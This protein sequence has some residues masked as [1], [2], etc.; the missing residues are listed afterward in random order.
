[1]VDLAE[2]LGAQAE[3]SG[4]I[5]LRVAAHVVLDARMELLAL[6][7]EPGLVGAVLRLDEDRVRV[8]VLPLARQ[9]AAALQ[10]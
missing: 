10:Q 1:M 2:I 3:Q 8:P 9:V 6:G 4:A 7:V 5:E